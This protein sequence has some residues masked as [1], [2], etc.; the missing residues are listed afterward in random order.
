[1]AENQPSSDGSKIIYRASITTRDGRVI[2]ASQYG[3]KAF[4]IHVTD[5]SE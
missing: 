1:M 4:P 3:L 2:Y 5:E